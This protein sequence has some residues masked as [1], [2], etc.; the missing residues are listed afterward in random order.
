MPNPS[1]EPWKLLDT[2]MWF[3]LDSPDCTNS[4][5]VQEKTRGGFSL[6]CS[7][8][9]RN[10]RAKQQMLEIVAAHNSKLQAKP[11]PAPSESR[12]RFEKALKSQWPNIEL[13]WCSDYS[14]E[15]HYD[16]GVTQHWWEIWQAAERDTREQCAQRWEERLPEPLVEV[17]MKGVICGFGLLL[18]CSSIGGVFVYAITWGGWGAFALIMAWAISMLYCC[19]NFAEGSRGETNRGK[20]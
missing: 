17:C 15:P 9:Y 4:Y 5:S 19:V 8:C 6:V 2:G 14:H 7:T 18:L 12:Q 13:S 20:E 1:P 10:E 16:S 11:S 3:F